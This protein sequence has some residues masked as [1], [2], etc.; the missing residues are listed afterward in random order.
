MSGRQG[1]GLPRRPV[2]STYWSEVTTKPEGLKK[3]K[4]IQG[5]KGPVR[6][7]QLLLATAENY[8]F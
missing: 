8:D 7:S 4:A 2:A 3:A 6:P 1:A 5:K